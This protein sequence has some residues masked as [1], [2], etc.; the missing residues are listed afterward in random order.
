[1]NSQLKNKHKMKH[2]FLINHLTLAFASLLLCVVFSSCNND[3][4][5]PEAGLRSYNFNPKVEVGQTWVRVDTINPFKPASYD[6]II[7]LEIKGAYSK[8]I[9][10][11]DTTSMETE[12]VN[13][14][15]KH[16]LK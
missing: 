1:M 9:W 12:L 13:C 14:C 16:L 6:T 11:S 7:V 8:V 10:N 5:L 3:T 2:K 4:N 15:R